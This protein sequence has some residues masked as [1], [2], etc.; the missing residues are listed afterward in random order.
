VLAAVGIFHDVWYY[1][2][3]IVVQE[4]AVLGNVQAGVAQGLTLVAAYSLAGGWPA[5]GHQR[6]TGSSVAPEEREHPALMNQA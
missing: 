4:Q 2:E 5:G 3:L 6:S 1:V